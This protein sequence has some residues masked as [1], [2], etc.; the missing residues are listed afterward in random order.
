MWRAWI[1][2]RS[3]RYWLCRLLLAL[4]H[5]VLQL[6]LRSEPGALSP[7][8]SLYELCHDVVRDAKPAET[9]LNVLRGALP[10]LE[11]AGARPS[12][13]QALADA[14]WLLDLETLA[15]AN[16]EEQRARFVALVKGVAG[17]V[18][19]R[20]VLEKTLEIK[21]LEG[22]LGGPAAAPEVF[23]ALLCWLAEAGVVKSGQQFFKQLVTFNTRIN[24]T[25]PTF[26]LL[27]EC[28]EGYAKLISELVFGNA[29]GDGRHVL[30]TIIG[31]FG[32]ELGRCADLALELWP[33]FPE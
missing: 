1:A 18:V 8:R 21:L 7:K 25:Q 20:E 3:L 19:A 28:S 4:T 12:F 6:F 11:G 26:F 23:H 17:G 16:A 10:D 15:R 32:L 5:V 14:L 24:L 29:A 27:H 31:H 13:E 33:R 9:A 2:L 30:Q 22:A